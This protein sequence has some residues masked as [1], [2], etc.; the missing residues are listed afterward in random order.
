MTSSEL[1]AAAAVNTAK[2]L[3]LALENNADFLHSNC[4]FFLC[5]DYFR[6]LLAMTPIAYL[7]ISLE[8]MKK[9]HLFT[10]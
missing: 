4:I 5:L 2:I 6:L 10:N 8:P 3:M 7:S 1:L 9:L